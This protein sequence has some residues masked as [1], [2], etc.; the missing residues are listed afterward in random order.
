MTAHANGDGRRILLGYI[1]LVS[2]VALWAV[3]SIIARVAVT[4]DIPPIGFAWWRWIAAFFMLLPFTARGVWQQRQLVFDRWRYFL[5]FSIV[6]VGCYNTFFYL[7]LQYTPVIQG[8]LIQAVLPVL[9]LLLGFGILGESISGR[10]WVGVVLSLTGVGLILLRGDLNV[11]GTM[12]FNVGDMWCFAA[13]LVWALQTFLI[14]WRPAEIPIMQ[15][16]TITIGIGIVCLAPVYFMEHSTGRTMPVDLGTVK[17]VFFVAFF[18]SVL[19][20]SLYNEGT[21]RVGGATAGYFGNLW[22]VFSAGLA[23]AILGEALAW[24]HLAGALA[25]FAGIWF[26][27]HKR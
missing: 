5:G 16:M 18:A 3:N 15:F 11:F 23:I 26:A 1:F 4:S 14:R 6:S 25:V 2:G 8:A 27:T 10:Q 19:G 17:S 24:Y 7:G 12:Q 22:P 21:Y 13:A 20:A 9:V